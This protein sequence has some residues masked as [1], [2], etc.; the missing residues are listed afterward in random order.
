MKYN[1]IV[2]VK[3]YRKQKIAHT[4]MLGLVERAKKEMS[5][6]GFCVTVN[7]DVMVTPSSYH[8]DAL[9]SALVQSTNKHYFSL[10]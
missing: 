8:A 3:R 5:S 9:Q 1:I 2:V 4:I 7:A 10:S 6:I